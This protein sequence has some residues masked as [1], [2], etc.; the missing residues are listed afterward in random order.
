MSRVNVG[1]VY[2]NNPEVFADQEKR[3]DDQQKNGTGPWLIIR[4]KGDDDS[5]MVKSLQDGRLFGPWASPRF[6]GVLD[7]FL[8]Q[9]YKANND[10]AILNGQNT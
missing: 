2:R 8:T 3:L 9:A 5:V 10:E 4:I 1:E 7:V 6:W